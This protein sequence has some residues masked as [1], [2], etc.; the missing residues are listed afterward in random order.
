MKKKSTSPQPPVSLHPTEEEIRDYARHLYVQ[1]GCLPGRDQDNWLEAEAC[2][3]ANIPKHRSHARLHQ[4]LN[5]ARTEDAAVVA[6][7]AIDAK[8]LAA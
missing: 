7:A 5:P 2:L 3:R 4:H 1:S 8:H 6:C